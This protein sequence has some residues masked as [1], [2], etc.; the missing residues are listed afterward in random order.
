MRKHFQ[1][2]VFSPE[3]IAPQSGALF[4]DVTD[5]IGR[6]RKDGTYTTKA[7]MECE[8]IQ[9]VKL[10]TNMSIEL[11]VEKHAGAFVTWAPIDRN[12]PFVKETYTGFQSSETGLALIRAMGG[13]IK[14]SVDTKNCRVSGIFSTI[15]GSIHIGLLLMKNKSFSD[16]E[17]AAIFL[18]EL[19]HVFTYFYYIGR[20]VITT[21]IIAQTAKIMYEIDDYQER[22]VV[23]KEA[24]RI[25]GVEVTDKER[26]AAAPKNA[27]SLTTQTVLV[28]SNAD[29]T[30]SETGNSIYELRSVEQL[31]DQF[32]TRHGAGRDLVI[33]LDKLFRGYWNS[34]TLNTTEHTMLEIIKL[35][36]FMIGLAIIPST[37]I[38][39]VLFSNPTRKIYDDPEARVRLIR[40][41]ITEELKD[42]DLPDQKR[43]QLLEDIDAVRA[44]EEG[45]DDKRSLLEMFWTKVIP[46]GRRAQNQLEAQKLIEALI[47][48]ELFEQAAKFKVGV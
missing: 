29:K 42:R 3:N 1:R 13:T 19:G 26:L 36:M 32:A 6:L 31:A 38:P 24:E 11:V 43:V 25:L 33:G 21:A 14:G 27:R 35:I 10:H 41:Q 17:L 37:V 44:I 7:I 30:R 18:H 20:A 46:S 23:L 39:W 22:V 45:L 28:S 15:M 16:S 2:G 5:A 48:N 4:K 8:I 47:S 12:H 40:Q 34:S 9:L